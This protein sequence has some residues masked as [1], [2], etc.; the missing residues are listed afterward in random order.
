MT[1]MQNVNQT[2]AADDATKVNLR[3]AKDWLSG[4]VDIRLPKAWLAA[5][6]ALAAVLLIIAL[7]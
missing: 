3:K 1:D 4:D 6:A 5:G 2:S 7:D